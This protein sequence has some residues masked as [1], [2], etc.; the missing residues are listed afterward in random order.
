MI[1][2]GQIPL[3]TETIYSYKP[4]ALQFLSLIFLFLVD[5]ETQNQRS[6]LFIE[7]KWW[8]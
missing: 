2:I 3:I 5:E 7:S 6:H 8:R 1:M 4:N